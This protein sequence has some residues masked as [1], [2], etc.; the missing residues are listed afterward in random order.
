MSSYFGFKCKYAV[1]ESLRDNY[2]KGIW[3]LFTFKPT[4]TYCKKCKCVCSARYRNGKWR[5]DNY[6]KS[7]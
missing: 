2:S 4:F 6:E 7:N 1:E 5:C 3:D